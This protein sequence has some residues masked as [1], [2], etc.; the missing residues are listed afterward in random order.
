MEYP[1]G[2]RLIRSFAFIEEASFCTISR[3][4]ILEMKA[5]PL[6]SHSKSG[7]SLNRTNVL[8]E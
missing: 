6:Y 8:S 2:L 4:K 5:N 1:T 3:L 7:P